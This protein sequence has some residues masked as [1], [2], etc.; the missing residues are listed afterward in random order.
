M[1]NTEEK[2][3][4]DFQLQLAEMYSGIN[5]HRSWHEKY[6]YLARTTGILTQNLLRKTAS[7][8]DFVRP[9]SWLISLANEMNVNLET[10]FIAKFPKICPYC[11]ESV[12][13]CL[14]TNKK[15]KEPDMPAYKMR[16]RRVYHTERWMQF[17]SR[18]F[19]SFSSNLETIYPANKIIWSHSGPS[20]VC[21]KLFEEV[22]ELQEAIA[23]NKVN[24]F[25]QS[26]VEEE[27]ADVLAWLLVAWS[28]QFPKADI[29][30][31]LKDYFYEGCPVCKNQV[32]ACSTDEARIQ[33]I[34]D[35]EK[36]KSLREEFEAL[37]PVL[38]E[39]GI[40]LKDIVL[41]LKEIEASQSETLVNAAAEETRTLLDKIK[42]KAS[43]SGMESVSTLVNNAVQVFGNLS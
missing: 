13:C 37:A 3:V 1:S 33:S 43:L 28:C 7:K 39:H 11:L 41:S 5:E 12:C 31:Y 34:V 16:E 36:F 15:P 8:Q 38:H 6:G 29:S 2:K 35:A 21:S 24:K 20:T 32:C 10:A 23:K 26:A 17:S 22:A 40:E 4:N 42:D 30:E 25:S 18:T 9:L 19:H 14:D 27:F